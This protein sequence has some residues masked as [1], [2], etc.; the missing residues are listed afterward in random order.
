MQLLGAQF[1]VLFFPLPFSFPPFLSLP[2]YTYSVFD[3]IWAEALNTIYMLIASLFT[4]LPMTSPELKF[5]P[6]NPTAYP[7]PPLRNAIASQALTCLHR[8]PGVFSPHLLL[9]QVFVI[10]VEHTCSPWT[11]LFPPTS[12]SNHQHI[13]LSLLSDQDV[14][15]TS[16]SIRAALILA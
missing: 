10:Q 1:S 2:I 8:A 16:T 15:S 7:T 5:R 11:T 6:S 4:S 13:P 3:L 9:S 12:Y 14:S